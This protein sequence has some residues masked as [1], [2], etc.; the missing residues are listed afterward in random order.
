[1]RTTNKNEEKKKKKWTHVRASLLP[2]T[3]LHLLLLRLRGMRR[4]RLSVLLGVCTRLGV[5]LGDGR[6]L[7]G[8]RAKEGV[9]E[10]GRGHWRLLLGVSVGISKPWAM[11]KQ[12]GVGKGRLFSHRLLGNTE[13][14]ISFDTRLK[15]CSLECLENAR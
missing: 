11:G 10:G 3:Y 13:R 4:L 6:T 1:M 15:T 2:F 7:N 14:K 12:Q 8:G 5:L 9:G